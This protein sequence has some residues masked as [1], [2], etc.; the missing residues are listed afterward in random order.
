MLMLDDSFT[1]I[2]KLAVYD[3]WAW[4]CIY[5]YVAMF[6]GFQRPWDRLTSWQSGR[7]LIIKLVE[8]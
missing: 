8:I 4:I 3:I 7:Y 1:T 6:S 2:E 5:L